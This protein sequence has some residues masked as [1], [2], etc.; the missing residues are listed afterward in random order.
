MTAISFM[1]FAGAAGIFAA[2][3]WLGRATKK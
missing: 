3:F 1:V 2:G